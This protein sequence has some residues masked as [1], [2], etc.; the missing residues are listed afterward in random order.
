[1]IKDWFRLVLWYVRIRKA[2]KTGQIHSSLLEIESRATI[3]QSIIDNPKRQLQIKKFDEVHDRPDE[4]NVTSG[5]TSTES[6][7]YIEKQVVQTITEAMKRSSRAKREFF[8]GCK[9]QIRVHTIE[10]RIHST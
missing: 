2:H 10:L 3:K 9:F 1:M 4:S 6:S 8:S 7:D 5:S